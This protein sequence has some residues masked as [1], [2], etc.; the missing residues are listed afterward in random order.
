M[1]EDVETKSNRPSRNDDGGNDLGRGV[2]QGRKFRLD[3]VTRIQ[4]H[5]YVLANSDAVAQF[6]ESVIYYPFVIFI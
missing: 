1:A 4:A 6:I 5:R 2:R 3:S